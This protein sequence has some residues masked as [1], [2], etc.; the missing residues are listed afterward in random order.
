MWWKMRKATLPRRYSFVIHRRSPA[1]PNP[2]FLLQ[3]VNRGKLQLLSPIAAF[4]RTAQGEGRPKASCVLLFQSG[5]HIKKGS[6]HLEH[7]G[8]HAKNSP[9]NPPCPLP[10]HRYFAA[11]LQ[12]N[13]SPARRSKR[14]TEQARPGGRALFLSVPWFQFRYRRYGQTEYK[15]TYSKYNW[16]TGRRQVIVSLETAAPCI[17]FFLACKRIHLYCLLKQAGADCLWRLS[18]PDAASCEAGQIKTQ[19]DRR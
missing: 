13:L 8:F 6:F 4:L 1:L 7:K 15:L 16:W 18:V 11:L 19:D 5:N 9:A 3:P 10:L 17:S 12:R 14:E 2:T